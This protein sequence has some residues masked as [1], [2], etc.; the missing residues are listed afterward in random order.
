MRIVAI[1]PS[2]Y[3]S[4]RLEG[5]PLIDI[6]GKPMIQWVYESAQQAQLVDRVIVA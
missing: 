6:A 2:R 3:Y 5:K 4:T 1:I